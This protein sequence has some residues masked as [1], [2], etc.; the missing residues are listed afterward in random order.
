MR[1]GPVQTGQ[2]SLGGRDL[3]PGI[4]AMPH[5]RM[6]APHCLGALLAPTDLPVRAIAWRTPQLPHA[7]IQGQSWTCTDGLAAGL[8]DG[9][10][11]VLASPCPQPG[12]TRGGGQ[13]H[14]THT[15][16]PSLLSLIRVLGSQ[17]RWAGGPEPRPVKLSTNPLASWGKATQR[18]VRGG[19]VHSCC[20][21][22][23]TGGCQHQ[24]KTHPQV[25]IRSPLALAQRR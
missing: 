13:S 22:A 14:P 4:L 3:H 21:P 5:T 16:P 2:G 23:P 11:S 25:A 18:G 1:Q 6:G 9:N 24:Q 7:R 19:R 17:G 15:N 8:S 10:A 12:P 20:L